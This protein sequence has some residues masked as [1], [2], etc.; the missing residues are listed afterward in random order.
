LNE[1]TLIFQTARARIF[2]AYKLKVVQRRPPPSQKGENFAITKVNE[3]HMYV[4]T[5]SQYKEAA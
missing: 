2:T 3:T 4:I 1:S 5:L